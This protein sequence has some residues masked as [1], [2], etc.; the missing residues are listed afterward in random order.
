MVTTLQQA[1]AQHQS[2][3]RVAES[4]ARLRSHSKTI[5][6]EGQTAVQQQDE[7]HD[8]A[9]IGERAT[10]GEG[11]DGAAPGEGATHE[12]RSAQEPPTGEEEVPPPTPAEEDAAAEETS[13]PAAEA[14]VAD[15]AA[16]G[17]KQAAKQ[18][19]WSKSDDQTSEGAS[20]PGG[21][22]IGTPRDGFTLAHL[23]A[24]RYLCIPELSEESK[25]ESESENNVF[26]L[27]ALMSPEN[28]T[29][30]VMD[31]LLQQI[32]TDLKHK[33]QAKLENYLTPSAFPVS[34]KA[35]RSMQHKLDVAQTALDE[36]V[37]G[38]E[39]TKE[40]LRKLEQMPG[41][42]V[43]ARRMLDDLT[44]LQDV[45]SL[46]DAEISLCGD[47]I[48]Q[49]PKRICVQESAMRQIS[50]ALTRMNNM[51]PED[52]LRAC[53]KEW[54]CASSWSATQEMCGSN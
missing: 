14:A 26:F 12:Q 54:F 50:R 3:S 38:H 20:R 29:E 39:E 24:L 21:G 4:E 13:A 32:G 34:P 15:P 48:A 42:P 52:E 46:K 11:A 8:A 17:E 47:I 36:S 7:T 18:S 30:A 16:E 53:V 23:D 45:C 43:A 9:T 49:S 19:V 27:N 40:S 44:A 31:N 28:I 6:D 41:S 1:A 5:S 37:C 22:T 33:L 10:P 25:Y 51:Q 35:R 2:Q